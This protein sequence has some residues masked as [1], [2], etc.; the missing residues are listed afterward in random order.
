M[1]FGVDP[2]DPNN[3]YIDGRGWVDDDL[4]RAWE[5]ARR[6]YRALTAELQEVLYGQPDHLDPPLPDPSIDVMRGQERRP[7][8]NAWIGRPKHTVKRDNN[9]AIDETR[10]VTVL[11]LAGD[12][13][14][15]DMEPDEVWALIREAE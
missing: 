2:S 3:D 14:S 9:L 4:Y 13:I 15:V 8:Q 1:D 7:F 6:T 5:T 10:L 11:V 12:V